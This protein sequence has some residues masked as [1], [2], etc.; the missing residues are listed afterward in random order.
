MTLGAALLALTVAAPATAAARAPLINLASA[1]KAS[2]PAAG[3]VY[4]GHTSQ[5]APIGVRVRRGGGALTQLLLHLQAQCDDGG[6]LN[7]AGVATFAAALPPTPDGENTAAPA[8][9]SRTGSFTARGSGLSRYGENMVGLL[10]ETISGRVRGA[11]A[12]GTL[13]ATFELFEISSGNRVTTCRTGNVRW[14]ARSAPGRTFAGLTS[15]RRPVVVELARDGSKVEDFRVTWDADCQPSGGLDIADSLINFPV[16]ATGRFGDSFSQELT[17]PGGGKQVFSYML[18]G[19][20]GR[21]R[22]SGRFQVTMSETDGAGAAVGSCDSTLL[23]W[24]A[25]SSPGRAPEVRPRRTR[26]R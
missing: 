17:P 22:A 24:S 16:S 15:D 25:T 7:W 8:R 18:D 14:A 9:L 23:S 1:A 4:G 11:D 19:D 6:R 12:R 20:A 2:G 3:T 21:T 10:T 5:Y 26:G 13:S